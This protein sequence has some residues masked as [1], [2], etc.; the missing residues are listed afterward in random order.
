MLPKF[1]RCTFLLLLL[2]LHSFFATS[3]LPLHFLPFHLLLFLEQHS[4]VLFIRYQHTP[5]WCHP[6]DQ[7]PVS[8]WWLKALQTADYPI[9]LFHN[10][11]RSP[12]WQLDEP[13]Q[14][15]C[16]WMIATSPSSFSFIIWH[17]NVRF[18][19]Y[20]YYCGTCWGSDMFTDRKA[21]SQFRVCVLESTQF[22]VAD[23]IA[24]RKVCSNS[25]NIK[26]YSK[27]DCKII[28]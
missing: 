2:L 15:E 26:A 24:L 14:E 16:N 11:S 17:L 10:M 23:V 9:T 8:W 19:Y 18:F 12:K 28:F 3:S 5:R 7:L 20:Y 21:V 22:N 4:K 13:L 27:C 1:P 6:F 25:L